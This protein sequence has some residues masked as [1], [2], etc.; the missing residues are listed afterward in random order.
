MLRLWR[1]GGLALDYRMPAQVMA[2]SGDTQ[3]VTLINKTSPFPVLSLSQILSQLCIETNLTRLS[4][5]FKLSM[6]NVSLL[7][8][9]V[10]A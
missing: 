9:H 8:E 1:L 5:L 3:Q 4:P 2:G 10:P 6:S 7:D